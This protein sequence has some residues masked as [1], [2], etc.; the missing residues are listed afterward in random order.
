MMITPEEYRKKVDEIGNKAK[1]IRT[2]NNLK[3]KEYKRKICEQKIL[4]QRER[5]RLKKIRRKHNQRIK[6]AISRQIKNNCGNTFTTRTK[7]C[8]SCGMCY[9]SLIAIHTLENTNSKCEKCK[10][11]IK[12]RTLKCSCKY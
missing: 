6:N 4:K 1:Q 9:D 5:K 3:K 7:E 12:F 2:E 10:V 8:D 11:N